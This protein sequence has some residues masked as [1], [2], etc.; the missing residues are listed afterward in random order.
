MTLSR[1]RE[2]EI[3]TGCYVAALTSLFLFILNFLWFICSETGE[4]GQLA[5]KIGAL[6]V[7]AFLMLETIVIT[8]YICKH[9]NKSRYLFRFTSRFQVQSRWL[10]KYLISPKPAN[11]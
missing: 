5:W 4:L 8:I 10:F 2:A 7:A 9:H 1:K 11:H 3:K 6:S